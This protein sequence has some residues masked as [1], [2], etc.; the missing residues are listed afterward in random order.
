MP[1]TNSISVHHRDHRFGNRPNLFLYVQYVE[2]G[3]SVLADIAPFPFYI[4][5]APRAERLVAR[6][7]QHDHA[8]LLH[9]PAEAKGVAH[10]ARGGRSESIA[11]TGTVNGD[12]RDSLIEI[13]Q[14]IFVFLNGSPSSLCHVVSIYSIYIRPFCTCSEM[15]ASSTSTFLTEWHSF[16]FVVANRRRS[17]L[18]SSLWK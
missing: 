2:S 12:A 1:P 17:A 8:H 9:L 10:L 4:L 5:I 13:E 3:H 7:G 11:I 18:C 14:D 15:Q 16:V 6:S